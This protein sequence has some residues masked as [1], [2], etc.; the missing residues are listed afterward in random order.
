MGSG[1][2]LEKIDDNQQLEK[3]TV[4]IGKK[5]HLASVERTKH[6]V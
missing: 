1:S 2:Y 6:E 3:I 5:A 4:L